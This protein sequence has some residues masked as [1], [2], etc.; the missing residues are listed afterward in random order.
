M[1][2]K[3]DSGF[4]DSVP[5]LVQ[6]VRGFKYLTISN[7]ALPFPW[8]RSV[9]DPE[10][11]DCAIAYLEKV[12]LAKEDPN[13]RTGGEL[14]RA[15]KYVKTRF[16]QLVGYAAVTLQGDCDLERWPGFDLVRHHG[17][18]RCRAPYRSLSPA[19]RAEI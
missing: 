7:P 9:P 13:I 11:L 3:P 2:K 8:P 6:K 19:Q 12:Y 18:N 14:G 17:E 10:K 15:R 4:I 16:S 1:A 5:E